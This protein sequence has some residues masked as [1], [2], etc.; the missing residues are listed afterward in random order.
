MRPPLTFFSLLSGS[1]L[2]ILLGAWGGRTFL[3]VRTSSGEDFSPAKPGAETV[4]ARQTAR[5]RAVVSEMRP[6]PLPGENREQVKKKLLEGISDDFA[7]RSLLERWAL[8]DPES[9]RIWMANI[10]EG[11]TKK[12]KLLYFGLLSLAIHNPGELNAFAR[13]SGPAYASLN[14]AEQIDILSRLSDDQLRSF[15]QAKGA[16]TVDH[17]VDR[18]RVIR[19][20]QLNGF[21]ATLRTLCQ[22]GENSETVNSKMLAML[23]SL[24]DSSPESL[25]KFYDQLHASNRWG[26]DDVLSY[27]VSTEMVKYNPELAVREALKLEGIIGSSASRSAYAAWCE[28]DPQA[29]LDFLPNSGIQEKDRQYNFLSALASKTKDPEILAEVK[30]MLEGLRKELDMK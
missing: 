29:A 12:H 18:S 22:S 23:N 3:P 14:V 30:P 20:I 24:P 25:S 9:L 21:D 28:K 8:E 6:A 26:N 10:P 4:A 17:I 13:E 2:L 19:E 7:D 15:E 1:V 11:M 27:T 16:K 5:D